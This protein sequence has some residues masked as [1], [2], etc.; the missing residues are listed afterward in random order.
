MSALLGAVP[1][2]PLLAA[3]GALA[4]GRRLRWGGGELV[5]AAIALSLLAL[6]FLVDGS[7][8]S[9]T[10]FE[11]GGYRLTVGL[12]ITRLTSFVGLV[13][14]GTALSVGIYS[15]GY[16]TDNSDRPRF[17]AELGLF[18]S[19]ML[20]LVL[21]DS[22]ALLFAAW[23]M[24]GVAS[25][26]LIGFRFDEAG[27]PAAAT[28]AFLMTRIG[29]VGLLLGWLLA[30]GAT[31][32]TDIAT[33]V[34]A[35][36][37]GQLAA[38]SVTL[39]AFLMLAGAI[40][41]SA[42]L[43]LIGWLP[44]AMIGPTPVSALLHSATMVAAGVFL[45]LRLYPLFQATPAAL[46]ALFWIGAATALLAGLVATAETDLKRVL[47]WSTS[48][49]LG[50]MM[51]ALGLGGPLAASFHLAVHAAFKST[52]FL[53][54]G[55]VQEQ[56]GTRDLR[57]LGGLIRSLP[58][59]GTV[60][61]VAALALA[62]VPP[63]SGFWSAEAILAAATRQGISAAL[64]IV[65][66]VFIAG[67]YIGRAVVATFFGARRGTDTVREVNWAM[68]IGMAQLALAAVAL[69]WLM[70]G[71]L[72]TPEPEIPWRLF[73]VVAGVVGLSV[74]AV[75]AWRNA[76]PS[77]GSWPARIGTGVMTA[78]MAPAHGTTWLAAKLDAAENALD[79]AT[80]AISNAAD[81]VAGSMRSVEHI[82]DTAA[83]RIVDAA[84]RLACGTEAAEH[85]LDTAAEATAETAWHLARGAEGTEAFGFGRGGDR[86][87]AGIAF[88][89]EQ[90]RML[91]TGQLY[92][93]TLGL[94]LWAAAALV[95]GSLMF[96]L[97]TGPT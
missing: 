27:A 92:F 29:D 89:G 79:R 69:G 15:L 41:K 95:A 66:L 85:A 8:L 94:F 96:W 25:Y 80:Q 33:L 5:V 70:A 52:L 14:A 54:A 91:Q 93:Y 38:M 26:L 19:A 57:R 67:L 61:L 53:A 42:Q 31:G 90:L 10:W 28:K 74:G 32:T 1:L 51:I 83:G 16:M 81:A 18:V 43:P 71:R 45:I 97:S 77:F 60:F 56:A 75:R 24:V 58:V 73:G 50:E 84:W 13:V 34:G 7:R 20:T 87:A 68:R 64:L 48:S 35:A 76:A 62:G 63:L 9:A 12:E 47:A 88:G 36:A 22:L 6:M 72:G 44:D 82:L 46:A 37:G 23:E 86:L 65:F 21:A 17:F 2:L 39:I 59:T 4:V 49:Q 30:L 3:S 40:G 55:A 78:T 11:T